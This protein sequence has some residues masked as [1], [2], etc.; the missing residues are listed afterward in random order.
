[1][2]IKRILTN[3]IGVYGD[4]DGMVSLPKIQALELEYD[5]KHAGSTEEAA[6]SEA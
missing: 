6:E 3:T 1:M 5:D 4:I 2:Q